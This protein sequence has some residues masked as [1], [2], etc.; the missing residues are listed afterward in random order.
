MKS[1]FLAVAWR[2]G[3]GIGIALI[4][5]LISWSLGNWN[6]EYVW[7]SG[8]GFV[9]VL[10]AMLPFTPGARRGD[11]RGNYFTSRSK[12]TAANKRTY[13][14]NTNFAITMA[15]IGLANIGIP[16]LIYYSRYWV[17]F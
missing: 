11:F 6:I 4:G 10:L 3:I 9:C 13:E 8:L 7:F 15:F 16:V 2:L 14:S 17:G 5:T 1:F 12:F